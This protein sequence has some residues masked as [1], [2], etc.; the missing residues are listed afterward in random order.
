[1]SRFCGLNRIGHRT[2]AQQMWIFHRLSKLQQSHTWRRG[3]FGGNSVNNSK[4][5]EICEKRKAQKITSLKIKEK[6]GFAWVSVCWGDFVHCRQI[7][8]LERVQFDLQ[9]RGV[10]T[11]CL[12]LSPFPVSSHHQE[13]W[14]FYGTGDPNLFTP[15]LPL[16]LGRVTNPTFIKLKRPLKLMCFF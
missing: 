15:H 13:F 3:R 1:M 16:F 14:H 12:G 6:H 2:W 8:K 7:K 11:I 5:S 10:F 9:N 4:P